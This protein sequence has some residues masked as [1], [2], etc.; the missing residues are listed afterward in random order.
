MLIVVFILFVV[1]GYVLFLFSLAHEN[2]RLL[3]FIKGGSTSLRRLLEME[4]TS[5]A[6]H[7][8]YYSDSPI[9]KTIYMWDSDHPCALIKLIGSIS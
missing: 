2:R 3:E 8:E 9:I 4:H 5:L 1:F 6:T 7:I